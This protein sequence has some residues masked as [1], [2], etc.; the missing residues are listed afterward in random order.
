MEYTCCGTCCC[1][2]HLSH[3]AP[4][5]YQHHA[6]C[7]SSCCATSTCV[8]HLVLLPKQDTTTHCQP[9]APPPLPVTVAVRM[10]TRRQAMAA[11]RKAS[12]NRPILAGNAPLNNGSLGS[13]AICG[14][15][16]L[17]ADNQVT[18]CRIVSTYSGGASSCSA[19]KIGDR[20]LATAGACVLM[21]WA[22][23]TIT[24]YTSD[25]QVPLQPVAH[26]H[27]QCVRAFAKYKHQLQPLATTTAVDV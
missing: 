12:P 11:S 9:A 4:T 3:F 23:L 21:N 26:S 7:A 25:T 22:L 10:N 19:V 2:L 5:V 18:N 13:Q 17:V 20:L 27:S 15:N 16:S 6:E 24:T 14:G 1:T 8:S